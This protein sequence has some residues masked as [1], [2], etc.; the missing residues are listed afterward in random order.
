MPTKSSP[1]KALLQLIDTT[2][3]HQLNNTS[4]S[5]K[6]HMA[7][8]LVVPPMLLPLA[9]PPAMVTVAMPRTQPKRKT[10]TTVSEMPNALSPIL[11]WLYCGPY[12][13]QQTQLIVE[14]TLL[15]TAHS[16]LLCHQ[17]HMP[18]PVY[19][20]HTSTVLPIPF[21]PQS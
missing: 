10:I 19:L 9:T 3:T 16:C 18:Q 8:Q 17:F 21:G 20:P 7:T 14:S 5:T 4:L 11:L 1:Q 6:I 15:F 13:I 12:K 2:I